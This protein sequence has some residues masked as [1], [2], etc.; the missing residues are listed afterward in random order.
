MDDTLRP[1]LCGV[2]F[3]PHW[4]HKFVLAMV[5]PTTPKA[6]T[7]S[8]AKDM[9]SRLLSDNY[10]VV[11]TMNSETH[12]LRPDNMPLKEVYDRVSTAI[13]KI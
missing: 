8:P 10:P 7:Q 1:D 2:L 3:E 9:I 5:D 11:V 13:G 4:A 6:W 12:F